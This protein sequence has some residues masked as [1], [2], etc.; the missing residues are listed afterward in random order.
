MK[1]HSNGGGLLLVLVLASLAAQQ[2]Y[3]Q[4]INSKSPYTFMI[5]CFSDNTLGSSIAI[6]ILWLIVLM[7]SS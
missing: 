6:A 4:T 2:V 7:S 5:N 1:A 3:C